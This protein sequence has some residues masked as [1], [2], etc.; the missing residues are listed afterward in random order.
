M[1]SK[2]FK[3]MQPGGVMAPALELINMQKLT[4]KSSKVSFLAINEREFP[5]LF[6]HPVVRQ[7]KMSKFLD[8]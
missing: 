4:D 2:T 6:K 3:E 5:L 8:E 1:P 7:Q